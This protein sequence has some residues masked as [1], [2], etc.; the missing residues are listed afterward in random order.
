MA[1]EWAAE[2]QHQYD[3]SGREHGVVLACYR[4]ACKRFSIDTDRVFLSGHAMG[5]DAAWDM[6]LSHPDRGPA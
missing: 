6:G 1:P 5:G 2:N 4:D 3:Y